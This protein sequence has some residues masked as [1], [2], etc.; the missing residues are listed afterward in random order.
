[1]SDPAQLDAFRATIHPDGRTERPPVKPPGVRSI[2]APT[3]LSAGELTCTDTVR[4][5][6]ESF[7]HPLMMPCS[8]I[9][10][11]AATVHTP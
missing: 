10:D 9:L 11:P 7:G 1:V 3:T 4:Q 5:V 8:V 2:A 6:K